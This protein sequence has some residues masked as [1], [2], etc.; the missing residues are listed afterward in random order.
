MMLASFFP[1]FVYFIFGLFL[2]VP[3]ISISHQQMNPLNGKHLRVLTMEVFH[4]I[5]YNYLIGIAKLNFSMRL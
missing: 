1:F 3:G 5:V 2:A 4:F